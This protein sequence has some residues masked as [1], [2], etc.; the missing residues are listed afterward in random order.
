MPIRRL[1]SGVAVSSS[2]RVGTSCRCSEDSF[3]NAGSGAE[4]KAGSDPRLSSELDTE[5]DAGLGAELG[6]G[7]DATALLMRL[8]VSLVMTSL[9][10]LH[11]Q[12][13]SN[14]VSPATAD[15]GA[16]RLL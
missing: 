10:L 9:Y 13:S 7:S 14:M 6:I 3:A 2:A 11:N 8:S 1:D 5:L 12:R 16:D 15:F 4:S